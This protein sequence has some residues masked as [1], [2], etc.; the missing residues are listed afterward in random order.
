MVCKLANKSTASGIRRSDLARTDIGMALW[1]KELGKVMSQKNTTPY[2]TRCG[3][4]LL[5]LTQNSS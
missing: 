1:L 2:L 3:V 4:H 5:L